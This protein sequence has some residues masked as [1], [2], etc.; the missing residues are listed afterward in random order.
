[1]IIHGISQRRLEILTDILF[2]IYTRLETHKYFYGPS[3]Q[4][5]ED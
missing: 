5:S 1:M 3:P 2:N 4:G